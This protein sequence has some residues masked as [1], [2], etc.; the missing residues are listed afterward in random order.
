M[1]SKRGKQWPELVLRSPNPCAM[2]V[3]AERNP[4]PL[5]RN[6]AAFHQVSLGL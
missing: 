5:P 6:P 1:F 3:L 4:I 2:L